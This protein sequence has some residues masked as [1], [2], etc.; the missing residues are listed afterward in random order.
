MSVAGATMALVG[1]LLVL[2]AFIM[3]IKFCLVHMYPKG[4]HNQKGT[5]KE[6]DNMERAEI[7][8]SNVD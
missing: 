3:M 8:V 7:G 5:S 4:Y 2:L 6:C 1:P